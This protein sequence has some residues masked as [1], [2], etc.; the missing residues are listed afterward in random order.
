[1]K[2]KA[3]S[4]SGFGRELPPEHVRTDLDDLS[5]TDAES[6]LDLQIVRLLA[7]HP[8]L[9]KRFGDQHLASLDDPSKRQLLA[10]MNSVLGVVTLRKGG[11]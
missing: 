6:E 11:G 8:S 3:D 2:Q 9:R 1:M 5:T 7:L 10:E 4:T